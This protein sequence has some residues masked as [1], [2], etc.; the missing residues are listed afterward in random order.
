M[1]AKIVRLGSESGWPN[2]CVNTSEEAPSANAKDSTTVPITYSGAT[3]ARSSRIRMPRISASTSGTISFASR[4][5]ARW[6]SCSSA[7]IP[8]TSASPPAGLARRGAQRL[9]GVQR[10]LGE[11]VDLQLELD[12]RPAA[13]RGLRVAVGVG[14]ERVLGQPR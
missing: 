7:V 8:P 5:S 13:V 14:H 1:N 12:R 3:T 2:T 9:H 6:L 11:R 4:A 10:A